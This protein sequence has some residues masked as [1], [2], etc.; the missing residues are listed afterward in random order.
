MRQAAARHANFSVRS[1][2]PPTLLGGRVTD[3]G[4]KR[5]AEAFTLGDGRW[6]EISG[7]RDEGRKRGSYRWRRLWRA[8][9]E[10]SEAERHQPASNQLSASTSGFTSSAPN[11]SSSLPLFSPLR[12]PE[13]D[14]AP[15]FHWCEGERG[16]QT[17][18]EGRWLEIK[19]HKR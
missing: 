3:P 4:G 5:E 11:L 17:E 9:S 8:G 12:L 14:L 1:G 18:R 13:I 10:G 6:V 7:G 2:Q 19:I 16:R 15:R